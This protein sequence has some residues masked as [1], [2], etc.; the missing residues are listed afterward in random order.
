MQ[1]PDQDYP[2][3]TEKKVL[4][5]KSVEIKFFYKKISKKAKGGNKPRRWKTIGEVLECH[6]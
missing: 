5:G 4:E 3:K 2:R 1:G 6:G